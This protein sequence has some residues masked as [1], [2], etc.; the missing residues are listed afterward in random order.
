[1]HLAMQDEQLDT[2]RSWGPQGFLMAWPLLL[3]LLQLHGSLHMLSF[4][5]KR[6]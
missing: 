1:M 2:R 4:V 5:Y 6:L 3:I